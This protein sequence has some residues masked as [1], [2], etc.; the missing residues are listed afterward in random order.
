MRVLGSKRA[1][2]RGQGGSPEEVAGCFLQKESEFTRWRKEGAS[3]EGR[4]EAVEMA[5]QLGCL[6]WGCDR[7]ELGWDTAG[8]VQQAKESVSK[9]DRGRF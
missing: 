8:C 7:D 6:S 9:R 1:R 4:E 2:V 3:G 5:W